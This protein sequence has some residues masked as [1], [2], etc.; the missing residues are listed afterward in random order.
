MASD[1]GPHAV[2]KVPDV[3]EHHILS[4]NRLAVD[5]AVDVFH[6]QGGG[7]GESLAVVDLIAV[8]A[9]NP[10]VAHPEGIG[11]TV[12]GTWNETVPG[13]RGVVRHLPVPVVRGAS[14]PADLKVLR[15]EIRAGDDRWVVVLPDNIVGGSLNVEI[16]TPVGVMCVVEAGTR[17]GG[18]SKAEARPDA[19][20]DVKAPLRFVAVPSRHQ[21]TDE[22]DFQPIDVD[23]HAAEI[24]A[25]NASVHNRG[26]R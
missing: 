7:R 8:V 17:A 4:V 12:V 1:S 15:M 19:P 11:K 13:A 20:V 2:G 26:G 5:E 3:P 21:D 23:G 18:G 16:E 9:E 14:E 24:A 10:Q 25:V 6:R 22:Y